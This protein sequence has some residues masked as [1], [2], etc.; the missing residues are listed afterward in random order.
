MLI[1]ARF[2][3]V[4]TGFWIGI[5]ENRKDPKKVG[6]C[7]VRILGFHSQSKQD[8][9]SEDLPWAYPIMP[10]NTQTQDTPMRTS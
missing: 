5:V 1:N 9:P 10:L 8:I 7:Q 3:A 4:N 6:R 2:F